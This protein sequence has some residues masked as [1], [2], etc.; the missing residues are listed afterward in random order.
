MNDEMN[1]GPGDDAIRVYV[2]R[3]FWPIGKLALASGVSEQEAAAMIAGACAPG[4][5]YAFDDKGWW[6]ALG[7]YRSGIA[8]GPSKDA[9]LWYSPAAAWS[10]RRARLARRGAASLTEAAG[11]NRDWFQAEFADALRA[12]PEAANAFPSCFDADGMVD[13]AAAGAQAFE[14][15]AAWLKG[16]YAVC[17]RIFSGQTCVA[18]ESLGATLKRHIADPAV[19]PMDH[20][21]LLAMCER[22]AQLMLP[23]APWER[24]VGTPGVTIDR[25]LRDLSLGGELPY[26][27][28]A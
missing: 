24:P 26:A 27:A 5:I 12:V 22:L 25:L 1:M 3:H 19:Q 4:V 28:S 14:E 6:S 7:G 21:D 16:G 23:F 9:E 13:R 10:L 8:G 2:V 11:A 15:W 18:K 17:L 20:G